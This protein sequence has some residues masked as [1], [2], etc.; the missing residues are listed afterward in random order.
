M[1]LKEVPPLTKEQ[2]RFVVETLKHE[3]SNPSQQRIARLKAAQKQAA[4][5][6]VVYH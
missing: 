2:Y 3:E 4:N 1:A 5:M 6:K